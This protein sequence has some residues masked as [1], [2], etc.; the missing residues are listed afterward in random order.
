MIFC[1]LKKGILRTWEHQK[2]KKTSFSK[3]VFN[4]FYSQEQKIVLKN[5]NQTTLN[6]LYYK[7][8]II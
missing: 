1:Y 4:V 3:H 5:T 8:K 2:Q 7:K 6:F